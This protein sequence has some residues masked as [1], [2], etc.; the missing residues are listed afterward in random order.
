MRLQIR[1]FGN[2][3]KHSGAVAKWS[4][5]EPETNGDNNYT[6]LP[7]RFSWLQFLNYFHH[8]LRSRSDSTL[9][10]I[11]IAVTYKGLR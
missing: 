11:R 7:N 1:S 2:N 3:P 8:I 6:H 9:E 4:K 10:R 5:T